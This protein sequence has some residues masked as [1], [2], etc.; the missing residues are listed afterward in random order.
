[1]YSQITEE[2]LFNETNINF[3]ALTRHLETGRIADMK[4]EC[5]INAA[6]GSAGDFCHVLSLSRS[7]V[8]ISRIQ[9]KLK[10]LRVRIRAEPRYLH[11]WVHSLVSRMQL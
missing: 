3:K 9:H 5:C 7:M 8:V 11:L 4:L 10:G 2:H 6:W 1:M